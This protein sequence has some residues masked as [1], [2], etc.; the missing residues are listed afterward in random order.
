MNEVEI[1][2]NG[3][4]DMSSPGKGG[5]LQTFDT[6]QVSVCGFLLLRDLYFHE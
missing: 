1:E 4:K 6:D 2:R 5:F 3:E